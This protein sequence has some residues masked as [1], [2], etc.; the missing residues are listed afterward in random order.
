MKRAKVIS[1]MALVLSFGCA[2][3]FWH[4]WRDQQANYRRVFQA[5][6]L[7]NQE[8]A[9]LRLENGRLVAQNQVL[10][11]KRDELVALFPEID[12][13]IRQLKVRLARAQSINTA[14][15]E[16]PTRATVV[17][18]DSIIFDTIQLSYFDYNDGFF[19]VRGRS[20]G[21]QLHLD[22]NYQDTLAQVVYHG[23]R[24]RPWLWIFSRR[25]LMQRVSLKNPNATI[26][27][28]K[29]IQIED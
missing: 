24:K 26:T 29:H 15:F 5:S 17:L 22:L 25:K 11:L 13:E 7:R 2:L 27:Y 18:R 21:N 6:E 20:I 12:D 10:S 4:Q 9:T 19:T 28:S 23:E 16:A 8:L 14:G 3:F 1:F